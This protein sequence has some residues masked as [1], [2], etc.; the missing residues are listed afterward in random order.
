[1]AF[2]IVRELGRPPRAHQLHGQQLIIGRAPQSGLVLPNS[3]V[4]RRHARITRAGE[5]WVVNDLGSTNGI[6]VNDS[7]T[8]ECELSHKDEIR[9]GRYR[10]LYLVES[11]MNALELE[12]VLNMPETRCSSLERD[13]KTTF[14]P[15][16]LQRSQIA[17]E[18]AKEQATLVRIGMDGGRWKP[19]ANTLRIGH[20]C[21]VSVPRRLLPG[22]AAELSWDG[23]KHVLRRL[24][25]LA[26]VLL[27]GASIKEARLKPGDQLE[28]QGV[29]F[30]FVHQPM[31]PVGRR[32]V[33]TVPMRRVLAPGSEDRARHR[34]A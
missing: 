29:P 31:Q 14:V 15:A 10:I 6:L 33:D 11:E 9:L 22:A 13:M 3:A 21:E 19:G 26:R 7:E 16:D 12:A 27:N 2:L 18:R 25:I 4:S 5:R 34:S 28:I 30:R 1:M 17:S 24:S 8:S 32:T 20:G 23:S